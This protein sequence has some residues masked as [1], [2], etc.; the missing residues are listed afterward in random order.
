MCP[1]SCKINDC[2][3]GDNVEWR[4]FVIKAVVKDG[5]VVP[6]EPL[7]EGWGEG[8]EVEIEKA[9][10]TCAAADGIHPGDAW[11]DEVER[12]AAQQDPAD[13]LRLQHAIDE[14]R[15]V[16]KELARQGKW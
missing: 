15:L 16:A 9:A 6:R 1:A 13:D 12:N 5:V 11:M 4:P 3:G 2:D 7:P 8:T 10:S 14:E